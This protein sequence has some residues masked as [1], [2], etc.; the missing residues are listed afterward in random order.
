MIDTEHYTVERYPDRPSWLAA[1]VLPDTVSIG[2]SEAAILWGCSPFGSETSLWAQKTGR[3]ERVDDD[4]EWLEIGQA[5][6][7]PIAQ[8]AAK[9][10]G[11]TLENWGAFTV[12]RSRQWPWL[13]ATLDRFQRLEDGSPWGPLEVKNRS[14][15]TREDWR[16]G[17]PLHVVLQA[18]AQMAVGGWAR[19]SIAVL[20]GGSAL[21]VVDIERDDE[22]I[23]M[24]ADRAWRFAEAVRTG[25]MPEPDGSEHTETAL[26]YMGRDL[27]AELAPLP[28]ELD[29]WAAA[30]VKLRALEKQVG[31]AKREAQN[32]IMAALVEAGVAKGQLPSGVV[33]NAV[34]VEKR[35]Y[36][37]EA[38]TQTQLRVKV[39]K[40]LTL[41]ELQP[42]AL[43]GDG[44]EQEEIEQ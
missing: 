13:T 42:M 3:A 37:V 39:P 33:V 10:T 43:L 19:A 31:A 30:L 1:R 32:R 20:R 18:Q 40:G 14:A 2:A 12:L 22:W 17:P 25:A 28:A 11:R 21:E 23:E 6:E 26:R 36:T 24:H 15:W 38:Q 7:E 8:L 44:R 35:A 34:R 5:L 41:P 29:H 9:R 27:R 4:A 16:E